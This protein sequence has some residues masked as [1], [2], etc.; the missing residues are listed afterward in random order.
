MFFRQFADETGDDVV[1]YPISSRSSISPKKLELAKQGSEDTTTVAI[2]TITVLVTV[3]FRWGFHNQSNKNNCD[4]SL[5]G[6]RVNCYYYCRQTFHSFEAMKEDIL[7]SIETAN[8]G[9]LNSEAP[10]ELILHCILDS[11]IEENGLD[12]RELLAGFNEFDSKMLK[13]LQRE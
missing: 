11:K 13:V 6:T 7:L 9:F 12:G 4:W 3:N 1:A 8:V 10:V 5:Q 2:V